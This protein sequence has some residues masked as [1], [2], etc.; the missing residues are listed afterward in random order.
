M[1]KYFYENVLT[2]TKSL[3]TLYLTGA[4]EC[5]NESVRKVLIN[6]LDEI[7]ILQDD[8]YQTM[9]EDGF[10]TVENLNKQDICMVYNKLKGDE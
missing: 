4:T 10:Y 2:L 1:E 9:S 5:A 6:G 3:A 8:I 7:L